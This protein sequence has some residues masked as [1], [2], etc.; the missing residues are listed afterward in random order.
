MKNRQPQPDDPATLEAALEMID[1]L[2]IL[3][4]GSIITAYCERGGDLNNEALVKGFSL[5]RTKLL[6]DEAER[7]GMF[8]NVAVS[9]QTAHAL[10][11][12]LLPPPLPFAARRPSAVH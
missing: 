4:A 8:V 11:A 6:L 7:S 1:G 5:A 10:R 3:L 2:K 9:P 12:A